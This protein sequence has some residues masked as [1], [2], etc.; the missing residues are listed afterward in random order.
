[1]NMRFQIRYLSGGDATFGPNFGGAS[2]FTNTRAGY[3]AQMS[4]R[5]AGY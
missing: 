1:M 5:S 2:V 4:Q 3:L